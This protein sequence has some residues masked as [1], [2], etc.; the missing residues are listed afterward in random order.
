M[1][2]PFLLHC[3]HYSN[4]QSLGV[5]R[6]PEG[7][8]IEGRPT[9]WSGIVALTALLLAAFGGFYYVARQVEDPRATLAVWIIGGLTILG[10]PLAVYF[11]Y[12]AERRRGPVLRYDAARERFELP[13]EGRS[14]TTAEVEWLQI[15]A[16]YSPEF[17]EY[18]AQFQMQA[19]GERFLLVPAHTAGNLKPL[20]SKLAALT[21]LPARMLKQRSAK[22]EAL[23][24][25]RCE[26]GCEARLRTVQSKR[27]RTAAAQGAACV[28]PPG[29]FCRGAPR[30]VRPFGH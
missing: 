7:C 24:E 19:G 23:E 10:T 14:F 27:R 1:S 16:A 18:L 29:G 26:A 13:R 12:R 17:T 20:L 8:V 5:E 21:G 28:S 6:T 11:Q 22:V 4:W 30:L 2:P 25:V 9:P 3:A 15:V